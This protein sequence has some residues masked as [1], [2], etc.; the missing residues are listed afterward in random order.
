MPWKVGT[1]SEVRLAFVQEIVE[2]KRSVAAKGI[3]TVIVSC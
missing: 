3:R 2:L 1:M